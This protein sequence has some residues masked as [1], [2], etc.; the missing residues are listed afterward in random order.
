[1]RF[2]HTPNFQAWFAGS[3]IT[4]TGVPGDSPRVVF[5]GTPHLKFR[6]FS[7]NPARRTIDSALSRCGFF[8]A[9][10][11]KEAQC[12]AWHPHLQR[13]GRTLS[14]CLAMRKPLR[15][16][17]RTL[18]KSEANHD[19]LADV[20]AW[21]KTSKFDGVIIENWHDGLGTGT[22]YIVFEPEQVKSAHHNNGEFN[23]TNLEIYA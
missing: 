22:Q 13:K 12:Y 21:A 11:K 15:V 14:V 17:G 7:H 1:M 19:K 6:Q 9:A 2:E 18:G 8:F 4:E 23:P 5:H 10:D 20:I 3:V 16:D